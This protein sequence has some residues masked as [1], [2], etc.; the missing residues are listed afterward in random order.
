MFRTPAPVLFNQEYPV[1][2]V[3]ERAIIV[4]LEHE[5]VGLARFRTQSGATRVYVCG[6]GAQRARAC[7]EE[8]VRDGCRELVSWGSAAGLDQRLIAGD[9][10]QVRGCWRDGVRS[11]ASAPEVWAA[12]AK[13]FPK[14]LFGDIAQAN[15]VLATPQHKRALAGLSGALAADMETGAIAAVAQAAGVRW[16]AVRVVTDTADTPLSPAIV[17][18][19]SPSGAL[20]VGNI[21]V[22]VLRRP[23]ELLALAQTAYAFAKTRATLRAIAK[24]F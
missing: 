20:A 1:S 11:E 9:V 13:R 12:I 14:A 10:L 2:D 18:A 22:A 15:D 21:A 8:A 24:V 16:G 17:N 23:V 3:R 19:L 7:A 5:A 6:V 4:A